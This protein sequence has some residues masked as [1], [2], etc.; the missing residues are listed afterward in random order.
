MV[1]HFRLTTLLRLRLEARDERRAELAKALRAEGVLQQQQQTLAHEASDLLAR[2]RSLVGPGEADLDALIQTQRYGLLLKSRSAQLAEQLAQV[3]A[4][5][6]RRREALVEADREVR[7]LEKLR[8]KQE[9][10]ERLA[11]ERRQQRLF[12]ERGTLGYIRREVQ[13]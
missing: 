2:S 11:D 3:V 13:P 10:A 4:E 5:V 6:A 12:D 7:I 8:D 1:F 9:A